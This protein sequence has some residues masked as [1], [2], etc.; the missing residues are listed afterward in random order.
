[1]PW[2]EQLPSGAWRACWR[3]RATRK[4]RSTTIDPST[5]QRI[6]RKPQA[7]RVAGEMESKNRRGERTNDGRC[8]TWGEWRPMWLSARSVEPST[9]EVDGIRIDAYLTPR[10]ESTRL[11]AITRREVQAWVKE[12]NDGHLA[13]ASVEKVYRLFSASLT[14]AVKDEAIPLTVNPC[15][16]V[17]LPTIAPGHERY[18]TRLEVDLIVDLLPT[19]RH[20]LPVILAS[21]TGMRW[22][23]VTGLHWQ[24]VDLGEGLID[25]VETWDPTAGRI[26]SYPKGRAR[27]SVPIPAGLAR[28]LGEAWDR[29]PAGVVTCGQPHAPGGAAC[30]SGL[31]APSP[32]GKPFNGRNFGRRDWRDALAAAKIP[33][34][35]LHDLRHSYASWLVQAGVPLQEV[36]RLLGHASIIT[37]QRYAHLGTSQHERVLRTLD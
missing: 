33:P 11:N 15:A 4:V 8:P 14:A 2:A 26:K 25:V 5:N 32:T 20:R 31:V 23:E 21:L 19:D 24:R 34:A 27:R 6:S 9:A 18:L 29:Q 7:V 3:D 12:L 28:A 36:Q 17:E 22:G 16:G 1:M 13:P 10:W 35:R 30:R 37:T